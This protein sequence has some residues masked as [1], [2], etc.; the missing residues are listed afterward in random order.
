VEPA[1]SA[2]TAPGGDKPC[3]APPSDVRGGTL[4][5][6]GARQ[7][8]DGAGQGSRFRPASS[9]AQFHQ[10][11]QESRERLAC[12]RGRDQQHR[13]AGTRFRQKFELMLARRPASAGE[14]VQECLGKREGRIRRCLDIHDRRTTRALIGC[15]LIRHNAL[16]ALASGMMCRIISLPIQASELTA[17][18]DLS[19]PGPVA[20]TTR[21]GTGAPFSL[22]VTAWLSA[23]RLRPAS[24]IAVRTCAAP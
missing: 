23:R 2:D 5:F 15:R 14:P 17:G 16:T 8:R 3:G 6:P 11:R 19:R 1:I 21:L 7:R 4:P 24:A 20:T 22:R 12:T 9:S 10:A 18:I 13:A